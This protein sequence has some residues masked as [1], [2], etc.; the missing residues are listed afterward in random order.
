MHLLLLPQGTILELELLNQV[1]FESPL[2]CSAILP[3]RKF[4]LI[5]LI[6][7]LI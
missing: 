7:I 1:C 3:S 4:A 6:F 5:Y 2:M